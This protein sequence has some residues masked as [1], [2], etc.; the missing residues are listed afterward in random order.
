M[1]NKQLLCYLSIISNKVEGFKQFT[2]TSFVDSL[3]PELVV[4]IVDD[5]QLSGNPFILAQLCSYAF[6]Y[7]A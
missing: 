1:L 3:L 5:S 4:V 2:L 6:N 7:G